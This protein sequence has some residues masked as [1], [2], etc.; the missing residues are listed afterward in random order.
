MNQYLFTR[1][2]IQA[3]QEKD[4]HVFGTPLLVLL[5]CVCGL[6]KEELEKLGGGACSQFARFRV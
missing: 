5:A 1:Q 6:S 4:D 3:N 2:I